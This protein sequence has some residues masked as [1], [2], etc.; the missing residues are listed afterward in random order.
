[1]FGHAPLSERCEYASENVHLGRICCVKF[2]VPCH[3]FE[4]LNF[5]FLM[6]DVHWR[7]RGSISVRRLGLMVMKAIILRRGMQELKQTTH[8]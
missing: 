6:F 3:F 7:V 8:R 4:I 1:M 5:Q 2:L